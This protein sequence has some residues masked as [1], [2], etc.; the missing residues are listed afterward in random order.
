R[1][2][3]L[4]LAASHPD[5]R[6]LMASAA[7]L[8]AQPLPEQPDSLFLEFSQNGNRARW[9]KKAFARRGRIAVF[10]LAEGLENKGR[11]LA[12]LAQTIAALCAER[13]W[14]WSAHDGQ[15]HNF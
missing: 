13:T 10:T 5:L 12:P 1:A 9:E 7:Q 11:F 4:R 8:A 2:A 6:G 14:V 3:W 15:L